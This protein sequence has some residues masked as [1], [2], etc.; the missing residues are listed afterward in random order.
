MAEIP[1][2]VLSG[3]TPTQYCPL[4][5]ALRKSLSPYFTSLQTLQRFQ[6]LKLTE[7]SKLLDF[8]YLSFE[9]SLK[10]F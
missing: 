1:P 2:W 10:I 8:P 3:I 9:K 5:K 6:A 7:L 4:H